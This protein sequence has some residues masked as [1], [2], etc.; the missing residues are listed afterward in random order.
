MFERVRAG[1]KLASA[2]RKQVFSDKVLLSYM[3][4]SSA[5]I[6]LE[7]A[8]IFGTFIFINISALTTQAS[9]STPSAQSNPII[10]WEF[11][12]YL[13]LF[14]IVSS[15]T[16]AYMLLALFIAF[17]SYAAGTKISMSQ[18]LH[19]TA[20]YSTLLLEWAVFYSIIILLIRILELRF[21]GIGAAIL[22]LIAGVALSI[23]VMFAL[24]VIYEQHVGPIKAMKTS[25]S[26]FL[27]HFG[28]SVGGIA[29]SELY[30]LMFILFG[31]IV[32]GLAGATTSLLLAVLG[33]VIM[34]IFI[35]LGVTISSTTSNVF[36]LLLY[37]YA[38]GK[39][40]PAWLDENLVIKAI[41]YKKGQGPS[42][43]SQ[44]L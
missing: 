20:S 27:N 41:T 21:R 32:L 18:A 6:L 26:V 2:V 16:S 24:P 25:A 33:F 35:V 10:R 7:A 28:S 39:G 4:I 22:G 29:Y 17:K 12:G 44:K 15:F 9:Q 23:G 34:I 5:I 31:F 30:G 42:P 13:L 43:E 37:D 1:W 3:I 38:T 11:I 40:L 8:L 14:Y 19:Q 36:K